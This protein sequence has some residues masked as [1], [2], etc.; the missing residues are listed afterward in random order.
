M[1]NDWNS[2]SK[3]LDQ[4]N[5]PPDYSPLV[6]ALWTEARGG[7]HGAHEM[8]DDLGTTDAAWVHA[9]LHRREGDLS[10]ADY[11]YRRANRTRPTCSLEAEQKMLVEYFVEKGK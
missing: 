8:V 1:T 6:K 3:S 5:C 9:Y 7:W 2:F 10:N 11:W 4:A